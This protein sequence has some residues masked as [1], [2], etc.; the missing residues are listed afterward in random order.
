MSPAFF[1][2]Y[3]HVVGDSITVVVLQALNSGVFPNSL[4]HM[5]ITL[6]PKKKCPILVSDYR[7]ISL[8]NVIYKLIA[9]VL[10]NRLKTILPNVISRVRV[11]LSQGVLFRIM[12]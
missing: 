8:Y 5:H 12:Y 7:P 1:Q 11:L 10:S 2:K 4:N 3:W 9:K 6:I